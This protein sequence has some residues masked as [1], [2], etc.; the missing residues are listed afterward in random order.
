MNLTC[1][2]GIKMKAIEK[3][4][5]INCDF[6]ESFFMELPFSEISK[7][8]LLNYGRNRSIKK[9]RNDLNFLRLD[10]FKCIK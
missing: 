7:L 10:K 8:L 5:I 1:L 4:S 2:K 6:D 3:V 9:I